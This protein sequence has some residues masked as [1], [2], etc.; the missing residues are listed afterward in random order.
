MKCLKMK[1]KIIIIINTQKMQTRKRSL[2]KKEFQDKENVKKEE[3]QRK[4]NEIRK[5][6]VDIERG[7]LKWSTKKI[8]K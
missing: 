6:Y 7:S 3:I 8:N 1:K 2:T 4:R 5:S